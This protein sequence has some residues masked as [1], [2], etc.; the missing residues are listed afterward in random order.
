MARAGRKSAVKV[1]IGAA[2]IGVAS[3]VTAV[4]VTQ[5]ASIS[6]SLVD[7]T[8]LIV[9]GSSTNPSGEG[10]VD[11]F[12]GKFNNPIYTDDGSGEPDIIYVNFYDG[13][14]GIQAAI[15]STDPGERNAVLAS[16][17]GA[18]NASLLLLEDNPR[19]G[20]TVFILDN[21]VARPDGGFGTR[22]PLFALIG[23]NPYPTPSEIPRPRGRQ[24]RLRVRLQLERAG[25]RAEPVLR[26]QR[27]GRIPD[28]APEPGRTSTCPSTPTATRFTLRATRT[29]ARSPRAAPFSIAPTRDAVRPGRQDHRV[30]HDAEQ[31]HLRHLHGQRTAAD[32]ADPQLLR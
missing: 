17:W 19:L 28:H 12:G 26:S 10:V 8:A 15:D 5:P 20:N 31:H 4:A 6:A 27:T 7:L 25:V 30:R 32:H 14:A 21:D 3:S 22:Y 13:A 18:A 29:P 16:G 2:A 11:F 24:H 23:V 1:A 9:V